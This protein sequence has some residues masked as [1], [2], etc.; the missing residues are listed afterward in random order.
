[1][2]HQT[3]TAFAPTRKNGCLNAFKRV[4]S[5]LQTFTK[6]TLKQYLADLYVDLYVWI[7]SS[8]LIHLDL[9]VTCDS[10]DDDTC[11]AVLGRSG[12][13]G[14]SAALVAQPCERQPRQTRAEVVQGSSHGQA[15]GLVG[16]HGTRICGG[17]GT[18]RG[19]TSPGTRPKPALSPWL[20]RLAGPIIMLLYT[21][22]QSPVATKGITLF[23]MYRV[24]SKLKVLV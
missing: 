23:T 8:I 3:F 17:C 12:L 5:R 24:F 7:Y 10:H 1:M 11:S 18:H 14:C 15:L 20:S 2:L 13:P 16:L 21:N 19:W 4:C 9:F 6:K 22:I